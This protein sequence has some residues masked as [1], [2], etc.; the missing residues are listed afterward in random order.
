MTI[1]KSW[2]YG[3]IAAGALVLAAAGLAVGLA[4]GS[5]HSKSP[6]TG[7]ASAT[8]LTSAQQARLEHGLTA[9]AVSAQA[10]VVAPNVRSQFVAR[11]RLLLPAGTRVRIEPGT[12]K[13]TRSGIAVVAA[14]TTGPEAGRWELLLVRDGPNWS[15]IGT[16]RLS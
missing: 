3:G 12:F 6:S 14:D 16:R 11:G 9:A 10:A 15:L 5:S 2:L 1:A 7:Q 4:A 13:V 8:A